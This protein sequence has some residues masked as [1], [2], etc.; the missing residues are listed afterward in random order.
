[1][2]NCVAL[3]G[4]T[5]FIGRR[6]VDPLIGRGF[7]VRALCRR[8]QEAALPA[9]VTVIEGALEDEASLTR[10]IANADAVVHCAGLIKAAAPSD[11]DRINRLGTAL[12]AQACARQASPPRMIFLSSLAARHPQLSDYAA[13]KKRAEEELAEA[14]DSIHWTV[15]RPPAVYGPADPETFQLFRALRYG[16]LPAPA[17]GRARLSLIYVDDLCEAI[18]ALLSAQIESGLTFE[19]RDAC[20]EG[21]TWRAIAEASS[22]YLGRRI[23]RV[24]VPFNVMRALAGA[25][26][27]WSRITGRTPRISPGKVRE[28]FH[29]DWVC[30]DNT[31][32]RHTQ[33]R[34]KVDLAEGIRLTLSWYEN[35][36][37]L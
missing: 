21:Y 19:I 34:P 2:V 29:E 6:L 11:L 22:R 13:S 35:H 32:T 24:P 14:G 33:W 27:S 17:P 20:V 3:T 5:G 1:M 15:L 18:V 36:G 26:Q 4:A 10:L 25:N 37:W 16:L 23:L 28:L 30:R 8:P 7:E 9:G 12:L 31:L